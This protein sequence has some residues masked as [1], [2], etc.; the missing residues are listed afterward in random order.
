LIETDTSQ[1]RVAHSVSTSHLHSCCAHPGSLGTLPQPSSSV[2]R[3]GLGAGIPLP[4]ASA[5]PSPGAWSDCRPLPVLKLGRSLGRNGGR[6][7]VR[8]AVT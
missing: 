6:R 1:I 4:A 2:P 8:P 3:S 7:D 5:Y